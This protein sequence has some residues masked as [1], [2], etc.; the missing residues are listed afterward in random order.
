MEVDERQMLDELERRGGLARSQQILLALIGK[1]MA[2]E[3]AYRLVQ[4]LARQA[5][6]PGGDFRASCLAAEEVTAILSQAELIE[7]LS[8]DRYLGGID[9]S[10]LRLGLLSGQPGSGAE[11]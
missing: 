4:A 11:R 7:A 8:L 3:E 2:R 5:D 9:E 10:F 1:G 6:R